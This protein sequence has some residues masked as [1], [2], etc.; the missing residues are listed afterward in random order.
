MEKVH[1]EQ[2]RLL[3][4]EQLPVA[5]PIPLRP[6]QMERVKPWPQQ[7]QILETLPR[8]LRDHW[9]RHTEAPTYLLPQGKDRQ[10][11]LQCTQTSYDPLAKFVP[12]TIVIHPTRGDFI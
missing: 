6:D 4:I 7:A 11:L 5:T 10:T 8:G 12:D 9:C 2:R 1:E 3:V